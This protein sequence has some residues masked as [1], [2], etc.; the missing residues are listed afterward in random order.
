MSLRRNRKRRRARDIAVKAAK[1][2]AAGKAVAGAGR[3]AKGAAKGT[4][5]VKGAKALARRRPTPRRP[6]KLF[7]AVVGVAALGAVLR[8]RRREADLGLGPPNESVP[9]HEALEPARQQA[10]AAS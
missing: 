4:A 10:G 3:V 7:A 6:F 9:S 5:A 8:R 1:F 2:T